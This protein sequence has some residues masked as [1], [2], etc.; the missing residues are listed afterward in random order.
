MRIG[1]LG[2]ILDYEGYGVRTYLVGMLNA[3][4]ADESGHDIFVFVSGN[5]SP[6]PEIAVPGLQ[7]HSAGP[8]TDG[9]FSRMLWDHFYVGKMCRELDVDVLFAPAHIRPLFAPCP[10]VVTVHDMMYHLFPDDWSFA[11]QF[12]FRLGVNLLTGRAAHILADSDST[13]A[14]IIRILGVSGD[15][16]TT[17]YPGVPEFYYPRS[18]G[19]TAAVTGAEIHPYI[20]Y[21][22]SFHPRKN[23]PVLVEAFEKIADR[24]PHRLVIG[25][26]P[27]W[28]S[29][30]VRRQIEASPY[31]ERIYLTG[32]IPDER[33]PHY[34]SGAELF[35]FP[36]KYEGFGFP[37]LEAM[38]CGCPVLTSPV[39]SLPEVGGDAAAYAAPGDVEALAA[40]ML[41]ILTSPER[42]AAMRA[43]SLEQAERFSWGR[44]AASL[45][46]IFE[47]AVRAD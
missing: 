13:R 16:V 31:Q 39:S 29:D 22:G 34:F 42:L 44:A 40:E 26:K 20:F 24:V 28:Q 47:G 43:A 35:V 4:A 25:S 19:T 23:V 41:D 36:S 21:V 38:A 5:T 17:V 8:Q 33:L 14:D 9:A 2:R 27:E 6:P 30:A 10:V 15:R 1:V 32:Y 11:D 12:Y 46:E 37:V 18:E 7:F 3:L 45:L